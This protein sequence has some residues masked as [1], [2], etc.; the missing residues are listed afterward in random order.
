MA[1]ENLDTDL[2]PGKVYYPRSLPVASPAGRK[3]V[4]VSPR[5]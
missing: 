5:P 4:K 2:K 3:V 1:T